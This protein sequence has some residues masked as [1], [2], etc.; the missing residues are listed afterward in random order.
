MSSDRRFVYIPRPSKSGAPSVQPG[1][2]ERCM[3]ADMISSDLHVVEPLELWLEGIDRRYL[4][5]AP[6]V[7]EA[8]G[9]GRWIDD[10][11]ASRTNIAR[12]YGFDLKRAARG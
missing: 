8:G 7:V 5:Q 10:D 2:E 11:V 3:P 9:G 6:R 1:V 12:R 4:E